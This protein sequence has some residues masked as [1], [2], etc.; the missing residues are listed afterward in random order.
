M[1]VFD[2][3]KLRNEIDLSNRFCERVSRN[4][5][6]NLKVYEHE[7]EMIREDYRKVIEEVKEQFK[8]FEYLKK[9]YFE[10]ETSEEN[11]SES[12]KL[13]NLPKDIMTEKI[14]IRG[15]NSILAG[16]GTGL[17]V[18]AGAVGLMTAFGTASTGTAIASLTGAAKISALLAAFG[19][20]SIASGGLG[21]AGGMLWQD[22]LHTI[23]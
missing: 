23:K 18:G 21:M 15:E 10:I 11:F 2:I 17:G 6:N 9:I 16:L 20:G 7:F 19:G 4:F 5:D 3:P 22:I 12:G 14:I 1:S 8:V 13:S